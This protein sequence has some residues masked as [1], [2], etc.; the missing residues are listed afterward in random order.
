MGSLSDSQE[1]IPAAARRPGTI[2]NCSARQSYGA[3]YLINLTP[4]L[5]YKSGKIMFLSSITAEVPNF[6]SVILF[7]S[8]ILGRTH[9]RKKRWVAC[10]TAKRP[11]QPRLHDQERSSTAPPGE[12]TVLNSRIQRGSLSDSQEAIP[13]AVTRPG[14]ILNCSARR[15]YGAG[16][17]ALASWPLFIHQA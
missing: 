5:L 16:T 12:G 7:C 6:H 13:A 14:T 10:Q 8:S 1:A 4:S 11:S 9:Q 3:G 15:R 2:L 17:H